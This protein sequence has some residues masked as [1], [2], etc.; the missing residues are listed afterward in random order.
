MFLLVTKSVVFRHVGVVVTKEPVVA[1]K[2]QSLSFSL[3]LKMSQ[4]KSE[5]TILLGRTNSR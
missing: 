4:K 2:F 3:N 1:P 5:L